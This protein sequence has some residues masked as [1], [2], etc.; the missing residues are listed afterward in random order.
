MAKELAFSE[1]SCSS[2]YFLSSLEPSLVRECCTIA[3][4][5]LDQGMHL[6]PKKLSKAASRLQVQ[7]ESL[8]KCLLSL[9][10]LFLKA[11]KVSKPAKKLK[12]S[13]DL[14][15]IPHS[16]VISEFWIHEVQPAISK[17]TT[18]FL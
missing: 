11:T 15:D 5:I 4:K 17:Y 10:S 2:L 7:P 16:E 8:I 12:V 1:K 13:L 18:L 14:L 9:A 3:F 6:S